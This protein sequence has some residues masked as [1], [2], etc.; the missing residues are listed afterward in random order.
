MTQGKVNYSDDNHRTWE[1]L[2]KTQIIN[3]Q[4]LAYH[5]MLKCLEEFS[6]P[7]NYIPQLDEV[8][9]KLYKKTG[10]QVSK[11]DDLIDGEIFFQLLSDRMF[12]STIYIR[13][14]DEASLSRDPDIFHE[15]FGHCPILLDEMHANLFQKFG[16]LGLRLDQVQ[17]AFLQRLFWFTFE[18]GLIHTKHGLK[19]YGGSL[20]SSIKE[21]RYAVED[22]APLKQE[23]N[24][25]DMFRTSYR[26]DLLQSIYYVITDF[27]QL[28]SMLDDIELIKK[29]IE[30]AYELG[31]FP[32]SFPIEKPYIKY[33]SYN[34][35]QHVQGSQTTHYAHK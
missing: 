4:D 20:L 23:F 29:N 32:P 30:I 7:K 18:T 27:S 1:Y 22:S 6:L 28:H 8:S 33:M 12:P 5:R 16:S 10:W 9:Q 14:N 13:S 19:I 25:I 26:A 15:L 2:Y 21:S 34:I 11:V 17:R 24:M 31:E 35:C 3:L